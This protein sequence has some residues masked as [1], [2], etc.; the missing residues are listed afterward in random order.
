MGQSG[1]CD[2]GLASSIVNN[3][4]NITTTVDAFPHPLIWPIE[5]IK[6]SVWP[7]FLYIFGLC[8]TFT[9]IALI[10]DE[11][12]VPALER[13]SDRFSISP[14]IAGAT[15]M[16]AGGSM[17]E[18]ATT[19][20]GTF[21]ESAVGFGTIVG[22]AVFNVLLVIG[23]CAFLSLEVLELSYWP[24]FRD[25][26]FYV[27]CLALLAVF[28]GVTTP[29]RI[30]WYESLILL[31]LYGVYIV[32]MK[33][34]NRLKKVAER[35]VSYCKG[36]CK[37]SAVVCPARDKRDNGDPEKSDPEEPESKQSSTPRRFSVGI[38]RILMGKRLSKQMGWFAVTQVN[39]DALKTFAQ[40]DKD[41]DKEISKSEF[42]DFMRTMGHAPTEAEIANVLAAFN[43]AGRDTVTE[44]EFVKWYIRSK[45]R[46][47]LSLIRKFSALIQSDDALLTQNRLTEM[48]KELGVSDVAYAQMLAKQA[49]DS[50]RVPKGP[51]SQHSSSADDVSLKSVSETEIIDITASKHDTNRA[52]ATPT[53]QQPWVTGAFSPPPRT[54]ISFG[55]FKAWLSHN[56]D[57]KESKSKDD[58]D[59]EDGPLWIEWPTIESFSGKSTCKL[60]M[61]RLLFLWTL[62]LVILFVFTVPDVRRPP[63]KICSRTIT[64]EDWWIPTFV[65]SIGWITLFSWM[66]VWWTE[67]LGEVFGL[68]SAFMGLTFLAAGTSIPDLFSSVI[69]ARKG[70]GDMAVSSS[71]GSNIFDILVGLPL[72]W[73]I[74]A[75]YKGIISFG[76]CKNA[77]QVLQT[78]EWCFATA[79]K[80]KTLL[81]SVLLLIAMIVIV[82]S[83]V[84]CSGWRMTRCLGVFMLFCYVVFVV[85]DV[86]RNCDIVPDVAQYFTFLP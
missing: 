39:G 33:Y 86:L 2:A 40:I 16:A 4:A 78:N 47:H 23:V 65:L 60:L 31:A 41:G 6:T 83:A 49:F 32:I 10:C 57:R 7:I 44:E 69:V 46:V 24:L 61:A 77:Q 54:S 27:V 5:D 14:N 81:F 73:L 48:L 35:L 8:Y 64:W 58:D 67:V 52:F 1:S 15:L 11:F 51:L 28:F 80:A 29:N 55:E 26:V 12:F 19:M 74:Y 34:N 79:V 56:P 43:V 21:S 22:S 59:D 20:V 13:I 42:A 38:N 71:I 30:T 84:A 3:T 17:P 63:T 36:R 75:I 53:K 72:P 70:L 37:T 9:A 18:L 66:M 45:L 62:P 50:C 68:P 76:N 85:Q 82:I 25:S